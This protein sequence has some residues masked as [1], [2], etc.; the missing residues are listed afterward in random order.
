[1]GHH[2]SSV[3]WP[4]GVNVYLP[5]WPCQHTFAQPVPHSERARSACFAKA[6][7]A[8]QPEQSRALRWAYLPKP[9]VVFLALAFGAGG[10]LLLLPPA[11][12]SKGDKGEAPTTP[13]ATAAA[14]ATDTFCAGSAAAGAGAGAGAGAASAFGAACTCAA[15]SAFGTVAV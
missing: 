2:V 5:N 9:L 3:G 14:A 10:L 15:G 11:T 7:L 8:P 6:R 13:V 1:M 4:S 12:R